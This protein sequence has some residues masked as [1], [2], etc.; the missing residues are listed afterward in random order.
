[1]ATR[2]D[3]KMRTPERLLFAGGR[4]WVCSRAV[5]DVLEIAIGT[6][7]NLPYYGHD[8]SVTGIDLSPAMLTVARR[9]ANDLGRAVT[10]E[11]ADA[12]A[13]PFADASF[14]TVV[15]TLSLC[16]VPDDR[17]AVAEAWRVLRPGGRF[18]LLEHVRSANRLV[19]LGQRAVEPL[20]LRLDGDHQLREPRKHL[21]AQGFAIQTHESS[22]WGMI[23]RID[24]RRLA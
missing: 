21:L 11:T 3:E 1:M 8:A 24:A 5:G 16:T 10:L 15:S 14:D 9:R 20:T 4:E 18:L 7:L 13:L 19:R 2:Y 12:Q 22:R 17:A 23:E 6:G